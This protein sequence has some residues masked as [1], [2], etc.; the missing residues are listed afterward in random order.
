MRTPDTRRQLRKK[1]RLDATSIIDIS[2]VAFA[3]DVR[4]VHSKEEDPCY[5]HIMRKGGRLT[6]PRSDIQNFTKAELPRRLVG[7]GSTRVTRE[8]TRTTAAHGLSSKPATSTTATTSTPHTGNERN[9]SR[10][11]ATVHKLW[12]DSGTRRRSTPP[13]DQPFSPEL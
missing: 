9:T 5:R 4:V 7:T 10:A 1:Q 6:Q 11:R 13:R 2:S 8:L 3:D 12:R